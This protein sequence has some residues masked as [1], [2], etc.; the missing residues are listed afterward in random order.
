MDKRLQLFWD[1]LI[2]QCEQRNTF[3]FLFKIES[4]GILWTPWFIYANDASLQFTAND[5]SESD[6]KRLVDLKMIVLVEEIAPV[7]PLDLKIEK[8]QI[9]QHG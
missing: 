4:W 7:D 6:L 8:Y 9:K 1:E 2:T 3:E 5:I